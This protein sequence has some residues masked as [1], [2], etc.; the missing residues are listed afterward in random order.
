MQ[1]ISYYTLYKNV[2]YKKDSLLHLTYFLLKYL[3]FTLP[4]NF[5]YRYAYY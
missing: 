3:Y 5:V 4:C 2:K 1:Q